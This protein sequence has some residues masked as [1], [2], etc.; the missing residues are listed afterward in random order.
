MN[1]LIADDSK[2]NRLYIKKTIKHWFAHQ[3]KLDKIDMHEAN[4]GV[5][6]VKKI[7]ISN[8]DLVFFNMILKNLGGI[9]ILKAINSL[10]LEKKPI[11]VLNTSI[12]NKRYQSTAIDLGVNYYL[13]KP[14]DVNG[15]EYILNHIISPLDNSSKPDNITF[16][17]FA[18]DFE[19]S[20]YDDLKVDKNLMKSFNQSCKQISAKEFFKNE[21]NL[22]YIL[23]DIDEINDKTAQLISMLYTNNIF[24]N[25]NGI[26]DI[27]NKY[28]KS[29]S[30]FIDFVEISISLQL[31]IDIL[32]A[33][34]ENQEKVKFE[35]KDKEYMVN[36]LKAI[37]ED[38][39]HWNNHVF[40]IQDA[41]NVF[42]INASSLNSCIELEHFI[43]SK[44][45]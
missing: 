36:L 15:V 6:T 10:N 1:I 19:L 2:V 13:E 11:T 27:L 41:I 8:Y 12:N 39:S 22:E 31:F 44:I 45:I 17:E 18:S 37:L 4:D 35:E 34:Y 9:E 43:K 38:L 25:I 28:I 24:E 23:N 20:S 42:Y 32:T 40:I 14:L 33:L 5:E 3:M 16:N 26:I 7:K 30:V 21:T 29:L